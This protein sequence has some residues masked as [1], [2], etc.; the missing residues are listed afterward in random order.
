LKATLGLIRRLQREEAEVREARLQEEVLPAS[1]Y[2]HFPLIFYIQLR[3]AGEIGGVN[4]ERDNEIRR[5]LAE[6]RCVRHSSA[7]LHVA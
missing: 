2:S 6:E 1:Y 4:A 7:C 5:A 3:R